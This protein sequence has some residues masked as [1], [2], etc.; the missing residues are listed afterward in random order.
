MHA[1]QQVEWT[2]IFPLSVDLTQLDFVESLLNVIMIAWT[3]SNLSSLLLHLERLT[4]FQLSCNP[5]F[6]ECAVPPDE[7]TRNL[8]SEMELVQLI[9]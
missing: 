9:Y 5:Q 4:Y 2:N 3:V 7:N 1:P 8:R 6:R